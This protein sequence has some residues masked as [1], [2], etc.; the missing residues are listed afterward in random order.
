MDKDKDKDKDKDVVIIG[1]AKG[2]FDKVWEK[3]PSKIGKKNAERHFKAT[4]KTDEDLKNIQIALENYLKCDRVKKGYIQNGSTWFNDWQSWLTPPK[5]EM[6]KVGIE[7]F[8]VR[9]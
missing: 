5:T 1:V 8:E 7:Q 6:P 4:V 9:R 3:Y 2:S